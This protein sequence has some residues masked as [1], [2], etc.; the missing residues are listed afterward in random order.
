MNK[1]TEAFSRLITIMNEL[2][3]QCPWDIKQTMESLRYLTIEEMSLLYNN[4]KIKAFLTCTHGEGYGRPMAEAT[5]CDLPVIASNW[6][7]H[8]DFLNDKD[9]LLISGFLKEVPKSMIWK[10]IIIEPSKWYN[11]NEADVVRKLR[12][13]HKKHQ[14]ITKKAKRL[15]KKNRREISLKVMSDKFNKTLDKAVA[16]PVASFYKKITPDIVELGI[17]NSISNIDDISISLNNI[18]QGKFKD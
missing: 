18:L 7:G 16:T 14:L 11:V 9:S 3:E 2:R 15:G 1:K 10:P 8:L 17:Y 4:P 12:M 6:S 5:C 13:F